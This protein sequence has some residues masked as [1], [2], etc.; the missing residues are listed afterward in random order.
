MVFLSLYASPIRNGKIDAPN[1][2]STHG[3]SEV[4]ISNPGNYYQDCG[5]LNVSL[6]CRS[7][8]WLEIRS[9][10]TAGDT[11]TRF[12]EYLKHISTG[13][14]IWNWSRLLR[15][16][17][18]E[19]SQCVLKTSQI[20]Y[21]TKLSVVVIF[22]Q[23]YPLRNIQIL[24]KIAQNRR[25]AYND[26]LSSTTQLHYELDFCFLRHKRVGLRISRREAGNF[27]CGV[28]SHGNYVLQSCTPC[29]VVMRPTIVKNVNMLFWN[30]AHGVVGI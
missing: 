16:I 7:G 23:R 30:L 21:C 25:V 1:R 9:A 26:P 27:L 19:K 18:I 20:A 17:R 8:S 13:S 15:M 29:S 24:R 4:Q 28:C 3:P 22:C 6:W 10:V 2:E 5:V 11:Y 12:K 14:D